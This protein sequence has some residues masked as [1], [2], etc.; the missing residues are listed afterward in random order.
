MDLANLSDEELKK[1]AGEPDEM[2]VSGMSD[3]ELKRMAGL[4]DTS[5]IESGLRGA[6]QGVSLGFADELTGAL[7]SAF[8]DKTYEQ[9]RDESR[10]NYKKAETDNPIAY[11]AGQ[12]G[13][14]AATMFV[15]GLGAAKGVKGLATL[16][17]LAGLGSSEA[18]DAAGM[19]ADTAKGA[20]I[21]AATGMIP[22]LG[23][24]AKGQL[25]D[26]ANVPLNKAVQAAR[27]QFVPGLNTPVPMPAAPAPVQPGL[28]GRTMQ[29]VQNIG[30]QVPGAT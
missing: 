20:G 25:D 26:I 21:G 28:L 10:A 29:G 22:G 9:A 18:D 24:V 2:D 13:G 3:D 1:I 27:P 17:G 7:E 14:G 5:A 6:A 8:T 19:L 4:D 12:V 30:R 15:P 11:G 16:G 23:R